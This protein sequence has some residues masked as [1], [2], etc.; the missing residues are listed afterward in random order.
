MIKIISSEKSSIHTYASLYRI[1]YSLD[2]KKKTLSGKNYRDYLITEFPGT[3]FHYNS[4][5]Y[6][7][8]N[9][10]LFQYQN[11]HKVAK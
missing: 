11:G 3:I 2:S 8:L 1:F 6:S 9:S 4:G 10:Q 7:S 5:K